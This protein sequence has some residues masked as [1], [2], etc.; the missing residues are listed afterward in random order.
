M[1][2]DESSSEPLYHQIQQV[3]A[4]EI[5][6]G[7][8]DLTGRLPSERALAERFG[9]SRMTAR[10]AVQALRQGGGVYN[11]V[12]KGTYVRKL[13]FQH[14]L[15][16]L[17]SFSEDM[18]TAGIEPS[19]RVL[20]AEIIH[21]DEDIASRLNLEPGSRVAKLRRLRLANQKPVVI[22]T[23]YLQDALCPRL[24]EEHDFS[25]ESLF[26]VLRHDYGLTLARADQ[27]IRAGVANDEESDLLAIRDD[28]Y[29][30]VF[31][32]HGVCYTSRD[33]PVEYSFSVYRATFY[34]FHVSLHGTRARITVPPVAG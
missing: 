14:K 32:L 25:R 29:P 15:G 16:Q 1:G 27:T 6:Q 5:R 7:R 12:G 4:Q 30:L 34:E 31:Y 13:P 28:P 3:L 9:V 8:Y 10:Q 22:D 20:Q 17:I 18:R 24:L 33:W 19:S 26:R 21:C 11:R 2:T 23:C